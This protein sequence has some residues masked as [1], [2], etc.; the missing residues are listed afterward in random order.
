MNL[1]E[2]DRYQAIIILKKLIEEQ[3]SIIKPIQEIL[4]QLNRELNARQIANELFVNLDLIDVEELWHNSGSTQHGYV[5]PVDLAFDM[6][7]EVV[8][9][10]MEKFRKFLS[11]SRWEEAKI[12]C[13]GI[14]LGLNDFE[15]KS[16]SEFKDWAPDVS[17]TLQSNLL[18][19]W[20]K[21]C[22][23]QALID[24]VDDFYEALA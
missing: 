19:E 3:P 17:D 13:E 2:I 15:T 8:E 7:E 16:N 22:K 12:I 14:L 5:D 20:K 11:N 10:Y 4:N 23:K 18:D 6:V 24:E 9:F 21:G 1:D